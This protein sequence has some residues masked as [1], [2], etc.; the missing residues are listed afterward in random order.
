MNKCTILFFSM[1]LS[2]TSLCF[3]IS[4]ENGNTKSTNSNFNFKKLYTKNQFLALDYGVYDPEKAILYCNNQFM[5]AGE[6]WPTPAPGEK[7]LPNPEPT[8]LDCQNPGISGD[9]NAQIAYGCKT[10]LKKPNSIGARLARSVFKLDIPDNSN[11]A[12]CSAV[13]I[14]KQWALTA[15]HCVANIYGPDSGKFLNS[16]KFDPIFMT[17]RQSSGLIYKYL[18]DKIIIPANFNF[19]QSKTPNPYPTYLNED[20]ALLHISGPISPFYIPIEIA[21]TELPNDNLIPL[22]IAGYGV[23]ENNDSASEL[24]FRKIYHVTNIYG[25]WFSGTMAGDYND[26][27]TIDSMPTIYKEKQSAWSLSGPGDSGAPILSENNKKFHLEAVLSGGVFCNY[28]GYFAQTPYS[29]SRNVSLSRYYDLITAIINNTVDPDK[30]RCISPTGACTKN[31]MYVINRTSNMVTSYQPQ[32]NGTLN[33]ISSSPTG[34][35]PTQIATIDFGGDKQ[36]A[37]IT[38]YWDNSVSRYTIG[39]NG[40]LIKLGGDYQLSLPSMPG[41]IDIKILGHYA[42]ILERLTKALSV[43]RI[44]DDGNMHY[45]KFMST[46]TNPDS[47]EMLTADNSK[48]YALIT[49]NTSRIISVYQLDILDGSKSSFLKNFPVKPGVGDPIEIA[50]IP[51]KNSLFYLLTTKN[52]IIMRLVI[53]SSGNPFMEYLSQ[54]PREFDINSH[55]KPLSPSKPGELNSIWIST[56]PDN[57]VSRYTIDNLY[58]IS[59]TEVNISTEYPMGIETV[60]NHLYVTNFNQKIVTMFSNPASQAPKIEYIQ[61]EKGPSVISYIKW[62]IFAD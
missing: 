54:K 57:Q 44:S 15:A 28:A 45:I 12:T 18:I 29:Y 10:D 48:T 13:L 61:T 46:D 62:K 16:L 59:E 60:G 5:P 14:D 39:L 19:Y 42:Y 26:I 50:A 21:R 38:N 24:T 52:I 55:I 33:K 36:Y 47:M 8:P 6:I 7:L 58:R 4:N 9:L 25:G 20:F 27:Y 43:Y 53:N 41:P 23:N 34:E 32:T 37:F 2:I 49:E 40:Q 3:G 1:L 31:V 22:W 35:Y 56:G 11:T 17:S 51:N 30:I